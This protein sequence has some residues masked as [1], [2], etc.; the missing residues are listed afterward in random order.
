V[1]QLQPLIQLSI[2]ISA[3]VE[4]HIRRF[5]DERQVSNASYPSVAT[6]S[7]LDR[8]FSRTVVFQSFFPRPFNGTESL[9]AFLDPSTS[10]DH[11]RRHNGKKSIEPIWQVLN[12]KIQGFAQIEHCIHP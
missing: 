12:H 6:T 3:G 11:Y 7:L 2:A 10:H 1:I 9:F 5:W 8:P 4:S